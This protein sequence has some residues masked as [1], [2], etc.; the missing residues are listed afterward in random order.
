MVSWTLVGNKDFRISQ[1]DTLAIGCILAKTSCMR[2]FALLFSFLFLSQA[3]ADLSRWQK[4]EVERNDLHL[5]PAAYQALPSKAELQSYQTETLYVLEVNPE[6]VDFIKAQNIQPD[7][8]GKFKTPEG[9][10][11]FYIHPKATELFKDLIPLGNLKTVQVRPTTS[12]RTFFVG[13]VMVKVSLPQKING[14]IRTVYPLQMS[15]ATAISDEMAKIPDFY[16]LEEPL[17]IF[18]KTPDSPFG[19]IARKIPQDLISGEKTLV[20]LLS[21]TASAPDGSLL[22][23]DAAT[24]GVTP[25]DLVVNEVIPALIENFKK[26][27]SYGIVLEAHQQNTLLEIDKD[28][29]FTGRVYYRDLDGARLDFTLRKELG[30]HDENLLEKE[31]AN[32]IFD[33]ENMAQIRKHVIVPLARPKA[34]SPVLESSFR[35]YLMKSSVDLLQKKLSSLGYH[36]AIEKLVQAQ[37]VKPTVPQC[38]GIFTN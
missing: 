22:E 10:I 19:F 35:T 30:F 9:K 29:L 34:W 13:D 21:Y 27:A 7:F 15:R 1:Y 31:H 5:N 3:F 14:A 20:P 12:P 25:E 4:W 8:F 23:K 16:Y 33:L 11:K 32:W 28:G 24:R 18:D 17:A 37:L 6:K 38:H 36:P 2:N 26:A